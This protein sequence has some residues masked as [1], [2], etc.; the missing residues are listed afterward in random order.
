MK[1]LI[2]ILLTALIA[3]SAAVCASAATDTSL[4]RSKLGALIDASPYSGD[5]VGT[6]F[7]Y[8]FDGNGVKEL[9]TY[10]SVKGDVVPKKVMNVYTIKNGKAKSIVKNKKLF[11]EVGGPNGFTGVA[12]KGKTKFVICGGETGSTG[13]APGDKLNRYGS[14]TL[15]KIKGAKIVKKIK[16]SFNVTFKSKTKGI[17]VLKCKAK[18][19]GKIKSYK[20]FSKWLRAYKVSKV[21]KY[22]RGLFGVTYY[23]KGTSLNSLY[24]SL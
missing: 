8:D 14:I 18:V 1:K 3:S 7:F 5:Y 4:Y 6:G 21:S 11:L 9:V 2:S 16:A 15:Y 12:K 13:G 19:N 10:S 22:K 17:K 23:S 24:S 20:A